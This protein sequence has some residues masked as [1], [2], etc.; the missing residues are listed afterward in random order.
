LAW[1]ASGR[2]Q[3]PPTEPVVGFVSSYEVTRTLRAAGF[4]VLAPPLREGTTY[5]ARATD[6]RGLLM[7][8]VIDARTGAIRDATRIVPGPGRYGQ[9][10]GAP[11]P[12]YDPADFDASVPM[13]HAPEMEQPAAPI[14]PGPPMA[15]SLPLAPISPAMH[16]A[17]TGHLI[18]LPRRR[19]A[20]LASHHGVAPAVAVPSQGSPTL[21]TSVPLVAPARSGADAA[22]KPDG[23]AKPP[24]STEIIVTAPPPTAS[25]AP[26]SP[27]ASASP[28]KPAAVVPPMND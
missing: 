20:A 15:P 11:P 22:N 8:V 13:M 27:A 19:P 2:A 4:D 21:P 23:A 1:A 6:F 7:R 16:P 14:S 26:N 24:V 25:A 12:P 28:N 17:V 3:T 5:I 9:Y 10:Y 18:P